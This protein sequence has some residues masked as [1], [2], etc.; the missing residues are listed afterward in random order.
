M[1]S[2]KPDDLVPTDNNSHPIGHTFIDLKMDLSLL[3]HFSGLIVP[4]IS[5]CSLLGLDVDG[6]TLDLFGVP[7]W[8]ISKRGGE[9]R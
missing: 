1:H 4:L 8:K 2:E 9:T 3:S 6:S 5:K 7:D